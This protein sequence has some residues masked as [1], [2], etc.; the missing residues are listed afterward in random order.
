MHRIDNLSTISNRFSN[1]LWS[2]KNYLLYTYSDYNSMLYSD[3]KSHECVRL[4]AEESLPLVYK[5]AY[6]LSKCINYKG[7]SKTILPLTGMR[8]CE[9]TEADV[10]IVHEMNR[11]ARDPALLDAIREKYPLLKTVLMI[12][13]IIDSYPG[14]K[15][16]WSL[17]STNRSLWDVVVSFDQNDANSFGLLYFEGPYSSPGPDIMSLAAQPPLYDVYWAGVDKGRLCKL[18]DVFDFLSANGVSCRFDVVSRENQTPR[19]GI[20]LHEELLPYEV[21]LSRAARARALLEVL[22]VINHS[23]SS[24][25]L[26]ESVAMGK[27][28]ISN[29]ASLKYRSWFDSRQIFLFDES[30]DIDCSA[31]KRGLDHPVIDPERF[32]PINLLEQI[33]RYLSQA[34]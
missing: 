26:Y 13:N 12:T 33:N 11:L 34:R 25:R 17:V 16:F 4:K 19:K 22:A 30:E 3:L 1:R 20:F 15:E 31:V 7:F 32:S 28:L 29:N 5:A 23:G 10:L 8:S 14:S 2:Q 6:K 18:V 9:L 24:M 27:L 21:T